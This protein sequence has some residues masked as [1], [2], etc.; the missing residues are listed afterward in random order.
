MHLPSLQ[1]AP[2]QMKILSIAEGNWRN[3]AVLLAVRKVF[4]DNTEPNW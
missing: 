3:I 4:A 2:V 1:L